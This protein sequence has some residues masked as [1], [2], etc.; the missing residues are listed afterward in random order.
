MYYH[1]Q[2]TIQARDG[3]EKRWKSGDTSSSV[4]HSNTD[5]L[6]S[7]L[8][9]TLWSSNQPTARGICLKGPFSPIIA[10]MYV[11][12]WEGHIKIK[13]LLK[14]VIIPAMKITLIRLWVFFII[15]SILKWNSCIHS[16]ST[17]LS[18]YMNWTNIIFFQ[19]DGYKNE[20]FLYTLSL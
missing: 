1:P 19:W 5:W 12:I 9:A 4:E 17:Y 3:Q 14:C 20:I 11:T 10:G 18:N 8:V 16:K 6:W 2:K 15:Y 7:L 13:I